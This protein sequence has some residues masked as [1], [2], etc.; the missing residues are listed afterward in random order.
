[1]ITVVAT[2]EARV[3]QGDAVAVELRKLIA[4]TRAE[5]GCIAYDL[6]RSADDPRVFVFTELWESREALSAHAASKHM[7]AWAKAREGMLAG[8]VR[9]EALEAVD[10]KR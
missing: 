7:A 3:S 5:K 6:S 9:I 10:V 4:P 2:I 1:M 8:P